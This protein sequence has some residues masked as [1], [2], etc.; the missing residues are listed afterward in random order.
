MNEMLLNIISVIVTSI[1]IPLITYLGLKLN[2]YLQTK[3]KNNEVSKSVDLATK[4]V[5]LAVSSIMQTYV[6]DLKKN[7][8]FTPEAQ[9]QAFLAAKEKALKLINEET[10]NAIGAVFGG[11][12]EWLE[13]EI[14]NKVKELKE[15]K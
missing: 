10:K 12:N 13:A 6:D 7:N 15:G 5:T 8:E 3:I 14:E 11:F 1:L 2:T 4:A 9:K